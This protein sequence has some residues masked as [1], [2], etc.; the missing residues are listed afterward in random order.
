MTE[1]RELT[2]EEA[3]TMFLDHIKA[4]VSYWS[5]VDDRPCLGKM[6]GLVFSILAALDGASGGLPAFAV[7]PAPHPVDK[8]Y[9]RELGKN[10]W[11]EESVDISGSLH[12]SWQDARWHINPVRDIIRERDEAIELWKAEAM[13]GSGLR[14]ELQ[15]V[16]EENERLKEALSEVTDD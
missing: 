9:H 5:F 1:P 14:Q 12:D 7:K 4:L 6:N 8:E 2:G 13:S 3:R 11:P 15:E 10:W 16:R